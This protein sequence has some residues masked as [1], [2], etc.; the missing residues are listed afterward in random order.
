LLWTT[1][2]SFGY[3]VCD[4]A[5][6]CAVMVVVLSHTEYQR[7]FMRRMTNCHRRMTPSRCPFLSTTGNPLWVVFDNTWM[8]V[9][10]SVCV[11]VCVRV[12]CWS[13][14]PG[15]RLTLFRSGGSRSAVCSL[16]AWPGDASVVKQHRMSWRERT[17]VSALN[18]YT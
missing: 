7:L 12:S 9:S 14:I 18:L 8:T 3:V 16:R 5:C 17:A 6:A 11:C 4:G 2:M 1:I 13:H 15:G 10:T